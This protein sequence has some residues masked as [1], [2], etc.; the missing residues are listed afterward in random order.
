MINHLQSV[1]NVINMSFSQDIFVFQHYY[2]IM[3]KILLCAHV[4]AKFDNI[5]S[6][7]GEQ[8]HGSQLY[9]GLH[10]VIHDEACS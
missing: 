7:D 5:V 2:M 8:I 6:C 4:C 10:A 3:Y 1:E 9:K